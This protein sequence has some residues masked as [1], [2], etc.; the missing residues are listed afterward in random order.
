MNAVSMRKPWLPPRSSVAHFWSLSVMVD[1]W[2]KGV[3]GERIGKKKVGNK[4][5]VVLSGLGWDT[6][7]TVGDCGL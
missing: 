5:E 1:V 6:E 7:K 3:D 2:R 4:R